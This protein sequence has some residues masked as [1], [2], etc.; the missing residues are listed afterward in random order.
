MPRYEFLLQS[1]VTYA[2]LPTRTEYGEKR[3]LHG[4]GGELFHILRLRRQFP[5]IVLT[6][7]C[8]LGSESLDLR[9][10]GEMT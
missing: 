2:V 5:G 8:Q 9:D 10:R 1:E 7:G 6:G 3:A 4:A